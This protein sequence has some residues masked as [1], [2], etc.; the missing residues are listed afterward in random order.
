MPTATS[1]THN[2]ALIIPFR[3]RPR[4]E[5][6]RDAEGWLIIRGGHAWLAGDRLQA[7]REFGELEQIEQRGSVS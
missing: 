7:L 4:L 3:G 2:S 1:R 5:R 6:E